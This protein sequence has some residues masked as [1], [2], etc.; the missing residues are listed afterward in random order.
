MARPWIDTR[1]KELKDEGEIKSKT[2]LANALGIAPS[3]VS[4]IIRGERQVKGRE[5]DILATYLKLPRDAVLDLESNEDGPTFTYEQ[6]KASESRGRGTGG[7]ALEMHDVP[8]SGARDLPVF[9]RAL[10]SAAIITLNHDEP[11]EHIE[12]PG[13]LEG[14]PLAFAV[15]MH[16]TSMGDVVPDGSLCYI[17]PAKPVRLRDRVLVETI[18]GEGIIK[19]LAD[20]KEDYIILEQTNPK[21]TRRISR[22]KIRSLSKVVYVSYP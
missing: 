21:K 8:A 12:R 6:R 15:Y 18:G 13:E 3:A 1:I 20:Q 9:G 5:V 19:I 11:V 22:N 14:A 16:G 2:G 7:T 4:R 10:G 17:N